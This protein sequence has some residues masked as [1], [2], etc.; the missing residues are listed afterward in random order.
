MTKPPT[1]VIRERRC[2]HPTGKVS[3]PYDHPHTGVLT[4]Y[5]LPSHG[6]GTTKSRQVPSVSKE[7]LGGLGTVGVTPVRGGAWAARGLTL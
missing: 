3:G 7:M 1:P 2:T 5:L 6:D 4:R